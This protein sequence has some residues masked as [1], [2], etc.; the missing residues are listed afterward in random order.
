MPDLRGNAQSF[1]GN[2]RGGVPGTDHR[3]SLF[4]GEGRKREIKR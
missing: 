3:I 4:P 1:R 2:P